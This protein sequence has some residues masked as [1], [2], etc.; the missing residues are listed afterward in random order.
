MVLPHP[1]EP[2]LNDVPVAPRASDDTTL[3]IILESS[4]PSS[5]VAESTTIQP[6]VADPATEISIP[7]DKPAEKVGLG[8]KLRRRVSSVFHR[9]NRRSQGK[10]H[11]EP[12]GTEHLE[13][14]GTDV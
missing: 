1:I 5:P 14:G 3:P 8:Y 9:H 10:S 13:Q 2:Q 4:T 6:A 12:N 11:I 7:N